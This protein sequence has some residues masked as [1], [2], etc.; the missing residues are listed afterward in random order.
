MSFLCR[1]VVFGRLNRKAIGQ[2]ILFLI[3]LCKAINLKLQSP[4]TSFTYLRKKL[5]AANAKDVMWDMPRLGWCQC[6]T[7]ADNTWGTAAPGNLEQGKDMW[8]QVPLDFVN[9]GTLPQRNEMR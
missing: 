9:S 7:A 3:H 5:L 2:Y 8:R 6:Q 1:S 4:F